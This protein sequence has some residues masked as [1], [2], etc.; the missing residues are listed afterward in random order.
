M[1][2]RLPNYLKALGWIGGLLAFA[3]VYCVPR[4]PGTLFLVS[5]GRRRIWLRNSPSDT[6]IFFQVLVKRE[7]DTVEWAA[8]HQRLDQR[9]A[10]LLAAG[11]TP[12]IVDAG[13]NI[14]LASLWFSDRYPE[15]RIFAVEPDGGN[16]AVLR[17]NIVGR[18]NIT[19]L[20]GAVWDRISR[21]RIGNPEAGAGA[22][23]VVEDD[24]T[25]RAFTIPEIAAMPANGAL[26][27]VKIDIEG[28]EA[29]LF[30]SNV[31]WMGETSL[32]V[33][34]THDWLYPGAGTSRNLRRCIADAPI[35]LVFRGENLFCFATS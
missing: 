13:A 10:A 15:A 30:R 18:T 26:F 19:V 24:G 12:I 21:L 16:L 17:R 6:S 31:A 7:Y 33:I 34:E 8:Q 27:I 1:I 5:I 25:L 35:D 14:G 4:A 9:Y 11:R 22:F 23:Q 20:E 3:R 28:G 32:I 29:A 2:K